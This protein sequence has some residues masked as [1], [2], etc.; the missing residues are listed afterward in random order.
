ME[1]ANKEIRVPRSRRLPMATN[2][3]ASLRNRRRSR[4]G[5]VL[6]IVLGFAVVSFSIGTA[7]LEAHSSIV[8]EAENLLASSRATYLAGSG[9]DIAC[10]YLLYPPD[11]VADGAYWTGG[12]RINVDGSNDYVYIRVKQ[13]TTF[14]RLFQIDA[15][16]VAHDTDGDLRGK[17]GV[18]AHVLVR[19]EALISIP[20]ALLADKDLDA[21]SDVTVLGD[22]HSN[23][24]LIFR[25]T[26]EANV[27]AKKAIY[28]LTF[29]TPSSFTPFAPK[30]DAPKAQLDDYVQYTV[31]G[32]TCNAY[33]YGSNNMTTTD[34]AAL[35]SV[36]D[37]D[38]D[39]P[40]RIVVVPTGNLRI[41]DGVVLNGTLV[42]DGNLGLDNGGSRTIVAVPNY[43]AI[44]C[45][46]NIRARDD[47]AEIYVTGTVLCDQITTAT[48][49]DV[50]ISI[51]GAVVTEGANGIDTSSSSNPTIAL[52]WDDVYS[53][54]YDLSQ[55]GLPI[56]LID[57]SDY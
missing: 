3:I 34:A 50:V 57:W 9:V 44:V 33:I 42:I 4:G 1:S 41:S 17:R 35:N 37:A 20:Y 39:N 2:V 5:F 36:L 12:E 18:R 10:Q 19:P 53:T 52:K 51:T 56:T 46:G 13:D 14:S 16:G 48:K 24:D 54:Y 32:A 38:A 25:G 55:A 21:G 40:G 27:S 28:W 23:D 49:N 26:C 8:P 6:V 30:V 11:S 15:F 43:P 7:Y 31:D 45:S 22:M 29:S 47:G